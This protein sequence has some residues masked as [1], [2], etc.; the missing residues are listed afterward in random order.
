MPADQA[1]EARVYQLKVTLL[2]I[3]P[4]IWRRFQMLGT[5]TLG[6]LHLVLQVVMGW[7]GDH[8][9]QFLK[10]KMV[11]GPVGD[12]DGLDDAEDEAET[13]VCD[14]VSRARSKFIYEYDFGDGWEH[15]IVVEKTFAPEKD[16][17]YPVCLE[18]A[19]ACPPE[20]CGGAWGYASLLEIIRDPKH[21][22]H[23]ERLAWIGA[24]FDPEAF[25][26]ARVNR[27][28]RRLKRP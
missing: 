21:E 22:Q 10:D 27:E 11:Y 25:D 24:K 28:L 26:V 20:D 16:A 12:E 7:D 4:P 14:L 17:Q 15:E 18:G 19:R 9:H 8:L 5:T 6:E 2:G 23:Q 3:E 1:V 13:W